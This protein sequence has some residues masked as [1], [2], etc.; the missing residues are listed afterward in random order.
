MLKYLSGQ[1]GIAYYTIYKLVIIQKHSSRV[2]QSFLQYP[3]I[4]SL[5]KEP[6]FNETPLLKVGVIVC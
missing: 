5:E 2:E 4:W 1:G 3:F 6:V